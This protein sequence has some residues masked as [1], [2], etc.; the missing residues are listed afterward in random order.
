M[1]LYHVV[2][3]TRFNALKVLLDHPNVREFLPRVFLFFPRGRISCA[4]GYRRD[5]PSCS[6]WIVIW[7]WV[8]GL[9]AGCTN[10]SNLPPSELH[11]VMV[12]PLGPPRLDNVKPN[13]CRINST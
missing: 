1:G 13:P 12:W 3:P 8:V 7:S 9:N 2:A 10:G 4:R 5:L 11:A 6:G